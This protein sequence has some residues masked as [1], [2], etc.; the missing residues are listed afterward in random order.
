MQDT[1]ARQQPFVS[2]IVVNKDKKEL[3]QECLSSIF[4]QSYKNFE[5][6]VVDNASRDGSVEMVKKEFPDVRLIVSDKN[7][8]YC[9]GYN[10]GISEARG[11]YILCIN[12]DVFLDPDFLSHAIKGFSKNCRVGQVGGKIINSITN[13]IDSGGQFLSLSRRAIERGYGKDIKY[14]WPE[15]FIWGCPGCCV[16]YSRKMLEEI[17]L[18]NREYFDSSYKAYLEDLDLNWRA[19][20]FGWKAYY[21]P[22]AIAYHKRGQTGWINSYPF[23]YLNLSP[24]FKIQFILNRYATLIKNETWIGYLLHFP[25]I[26]SYDIYLWFFLFITSPRYIIKCWEKH[27]WFKQAMNKRKIIYQKIKECKNA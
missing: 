4:V 26:L 9:Q 10:L 17:K 3:L 2:I 25:F 7:L 19:N 1:K 15:G 8:Y 6:I 20:R 14:N 23:G 22:E 16:L 12:N 24:E 11:D 27:R 5:V 18:N 21:M 13:K